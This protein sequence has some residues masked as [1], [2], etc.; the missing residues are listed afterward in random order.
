M[1]TALFDHL[2]PERFVSL[3]TFR[4]SGSA[5]STPV[6]V[7]LDDGA[8][9]VTTPAGSGKVKRLR[10]NPEVELR[11]SSR[12]GSV[13]AGAPV[14]Q[15]TVELLTDPSSR[16]RPTRILRRKYGLEY[17]VVMG[18]EPL[19]RPRHCDRIKL[20]ITPA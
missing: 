15:G 13:D 3:T 1:L 10:N 11:P 16:K 17:V 19:T 2:D 5:I 4:S 14:A 7:G 6:W 18:I 8:L 9:V 20:R 12:T